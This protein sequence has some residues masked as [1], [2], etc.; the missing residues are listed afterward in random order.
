MLFS[1]ISFLYY[2]LVIVLAVYFLVPFKMKN[3]VLLISSLVFYFYGEPTYTLLILGTTMLSYVYGLLIDKSRGTVW[4]KVF[5]WTSVITSIGVLG[6]F[7]YS[8]FFITNMNLLLKTD[9]ALLGLALPIGIS[10][11]TFQTLLV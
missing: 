3:A 9:K 11:Y 7:K 4:S 2:F 5:V 10:F 8:D 1:S 6:F